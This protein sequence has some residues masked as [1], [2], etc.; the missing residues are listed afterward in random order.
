M[1]E[2]AIDGHANLGIEIIKLDG[3]CSENEV[4]EK[5]WSRLQRIP[6]DKM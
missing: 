5:I 1:Y 4:F 6:I 3:T 2:R